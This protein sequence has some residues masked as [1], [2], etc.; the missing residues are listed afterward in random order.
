MDI[1]PLIRIVQRA[2]VLHGVTHTIAGALAIGLVAGATGKPV[3]EAVLKWLGLLQTPITWKVSFA[4]ALI[5][6]Y[7]HIVLDGVMHRDMNPL[8]PFAA[9]NPLLGLLDVGLLHAL[10]AICGI[11]GTIAI[12]VRWSMRRDGSR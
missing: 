8:W 1:E 11:V 3:S 6:S 2:E 10:C 7:S 4:S 9:G 5:G 12:A